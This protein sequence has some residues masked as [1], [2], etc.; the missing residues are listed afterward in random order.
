LRPEHRANDF[1]DRDSFRGFYGGQVL[2]QQT[3]F[4]PPRPNLFQQEGLSCHQRQCQ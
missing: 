3:G 2:T 4:L 1:G